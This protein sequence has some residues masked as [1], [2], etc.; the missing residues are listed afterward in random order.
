M[1]DATHV[2]GLDFTVKDHSS[3]P[4]EKIAHSFER[5]HHA[6]E[7]LQHQLHGIGHHAAMSGLSMVGLGFGFHAMAEKAIEANQELETAAKRVAG[8]QY[9]FGGW[10]AGIDAQT[11]W[12]ESLEVGREVVEKLNQ[13]E[14]KLKMSRGELADVYKSAFALGT[15]HNLSQEEM[16][17]MTEKLAAAQKVLGTSAEAAGLNI[18]RM[19]MSGKVRGFDDFSKGIRFAIGDMKAFGKLTEENR[20]QKI[21]AAMGDLVPAAEGLGK[22]LGGAMFDAREAVEDLT[23]DLTS[24]VFKEVARTAAEWAKGLTE[25]RENGKSAAKVYAD[26]LVGAFHFLKD[27]TAFISDHWKSIA[28][29]FVATKMTSWIEVMA[30]SKWGG[31]GA[32]GGGLAGAAVGTMAVKAGVVNVGGGGL[33]AAVAETSA[34]EIRKKLGVGL[35]GTTQRLAGVAAK[36]TM[37]TE[38][39]GLLYVGLQGLAKVVDDMQTKNLAAHAAAPRA[40]DALTAGAK[41]MSSAMNERSVKETFGHL[42]SAFGAYNLKP[43]QMLSAS[44]LADELR[45][46]EPGLAAKQIGMYGIRGATATSVQGPGYIDEAA[47]RIAG[48]LNKFASQMLAAYPDLGKSENQV[49][50]AHTV[51]HIGTV[52]IHPEFKDPNP[53]KV[54]HRVVNGVVELANAP[55][56]SN[57]RMVPG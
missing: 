53:D 43:G 52:E 46:M 33:P 15:R 7:H 10:K 18:T 8:V 17:D 9:A 38:A 37:V 39:L 54:F 42:K 55:L 36:A 16:V 21:R 45:A 47:G 23:R 22:G 6:A 29:V 44:T 28:A 30:K 2:E 1:S 19:V 35:D 3:E 24:P 5:V 4:A 12:T 34:A 32:A 40:M 41:A 51:V 26:K 31:A 49:A 27:A 57:A 11:K 20:F 13:S 50:K 56:G 48:L 14:G 25:V